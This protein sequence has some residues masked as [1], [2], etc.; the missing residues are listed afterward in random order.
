[1]CFSPDL[2]YFKDEKTPLF[3]LYDA[4]ILSFLLYCFYILNENVKLKKIANLKPF[5]K[6]LIVENSGYIIKFFMNLIWN[7]KNYLI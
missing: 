7:K 6:D 5:T 1:M 4:Y 2:E 3:A